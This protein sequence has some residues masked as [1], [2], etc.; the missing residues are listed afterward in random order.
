MAPTLTFLGGAGTV[1]GSKFLLRHAGGALLVEAGLFQGLRPLRRRN[2]EPLP[3]DP[4]TLDAV[5]LT[6][7]HLDHCGYLPALGRQGLD[8]PVLATRST[9]RL[10]ELVLRDSAKL[11]E[12]D[13]AFAARGGWSRHAQPEPLYT[14]ADVERVLPRMREVPFGD[15]VTAAPGTALTLRPAGHILG[16]ATAL[17]EVDGTRILFSG[18]L[19]RPGHPLLVDPAP[20]PAADVVVVESTYGDRRHGGGADEQLADVVRRTV[21]RGGVVLVPAFAVDRTEVLLMSLRRLLVAGAVPDVPVYVDS[22]M[23]LGALRV[24]RQALVE[25]GTDIRPGIEDG[26]AVFERGNLHEVHTAAESR[27]LNDPGFPCIVVSASGM[28]TGGRVVHHLESLLPDPRNSVVLVG[29]Q[30][31]GTR[32]RD[33]AEG[34]GQLKMHGRYVRVRAEVA[35]VDGFSVHADA[36]EVLAWLGSAPAPPR[37]VYV[38]HG[39]PAASAALAGRIRAELDWLA[40]TPWDGERVRLD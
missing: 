32:G 25:G 10:A 1:T 8:A 15:R 33:L 38:V 12:E 37:A 20:P 27:T 3:V 7:A 18:D 14:A 9:I 16:S 13:A 26:L 21:D 31:V 24:Y 29:Y 19:G 34:A 17:V 36:D 6:H 30:A 28:G 40:V 22:P 5:V 11:Q 4:A 35:V 2:W 23:A 39:E